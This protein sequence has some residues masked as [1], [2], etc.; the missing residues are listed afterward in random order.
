MII[1]VGILCYIKS[2]H[3]ENRGI[4]C[5]DNRLNNGLQKLKQGVSVL[6]TLL[7]PRQMDK[8]LIKRGEIYGYLLF[9]RRVEFQHYSST[10]MQF[11]V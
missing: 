6:M 1:P 9:D 5:K 11:F 2:I 3:F 4:Y 10:G 7:I 8:S